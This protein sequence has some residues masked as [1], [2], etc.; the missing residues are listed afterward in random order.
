MEPPQE[1]RSLIDQLGQAFVQAIMTDEVGQGLILKIQETGF[2]VGIMLEATVALHQKNSDECDDSDE[3]A[4]QEDNHV[5]KLFPDLEDTN[6]Y[7]WSEE[8]KA[9]MCNFRISLD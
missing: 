9:L 1:V 3:M 4:S 7:E 6:N 8:D 2:D 5:P